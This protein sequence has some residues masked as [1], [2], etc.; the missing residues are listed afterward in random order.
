M[1]CE[2]VQKWVMLDINIKGGV[3]SFPSGQLIFGANKKESIFL[4]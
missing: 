3:K 1:M 2:N 4:R